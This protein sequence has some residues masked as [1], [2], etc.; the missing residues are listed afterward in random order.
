MQ[1]SN[2]FAANLPPP[3][4]K[5]TAMFNFDMAGAG[6]RAFA[7]I[8]PQPVELRAAVLK[9]DQ[10]RGLLIGTREMGPPG[11]RGGDVTAFWN[12]GVPCVYFMTNGP[13]PDYH[14]PGDSIFRV[15]PEI[16]AELAGLA[17]RAACIFADR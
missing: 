14:R 13:F 15:N 11:V 10:A 2:H 9:A 17:L 12:Q 7:S 5:M 4:E 1:G 16:M 8:S 3:F 6:N